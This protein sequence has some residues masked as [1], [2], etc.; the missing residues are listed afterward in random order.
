[1]YLIIR[2]PAKTRFE[3]PRSLIS[4]WID[5]ELS[6]LGTYE[7]GLCRYVDGM[8]GYVVRMCGYVLRMCEHVVG[9]VAGTYVCVCVC[10]C[11]RARVCVCSRNVRICSRPVWISSRNERL[12]SQMVE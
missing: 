10:V 6:F 5:K 1:M 12:W 8:F 3:H 4:L 11:A 7:V 9:Y 2:A